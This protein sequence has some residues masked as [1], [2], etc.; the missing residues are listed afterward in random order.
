MTE[1]FK[2]YVISLY[3]DIPNGVYEGLLSVL[4]M[5][6]VM[7]LAFCGIK[8]GLKYSTWLLLTEYVL[9]I[10]CSTIIFRKVSERVGHDFSPF[11]SYEAIQ[12]GRI[13]LLPENI[14]NVVVFVPVGILLGSLVRVKSSW[15]IV[16]FIGLCIS[17][18]IEAM[19]YF[20]HKG[21][22][23]MDDVMHNTLGCI[24]GYMLVKGSRLMVKSF[25]KK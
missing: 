24:L 17:I 9:L 7:M 19:Q 22:A 25:I 13:E 6:A 10:F 8:K 21:F 18:S 11:W 16:L 12:D 20:F 5:G 1:Q 23:E 4:C 3:Q 2:Q 14:M 15:L